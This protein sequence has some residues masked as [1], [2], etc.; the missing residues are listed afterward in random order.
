MYKDC[1]QLMMTTNMWKIF[2]EADINMYREKLNHTQS[3]RS[4]IVQVLKKMLETRD[5]AIEGHSERMQD[6]VVQLAV[7]SGLPEY[8]LNDLRL[9]ALFHDLGKVGIPDW[10]W[11]LLLI[12]SLS[13]MSRSMEKVI[14]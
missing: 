12:G 10:I 3:T 1:C 11:S 14:H 8:K 2:K 13:I 5:F 6:L 9:F 7:A 4:I